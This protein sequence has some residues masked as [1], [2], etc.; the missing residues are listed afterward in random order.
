ML[1][2]DLVRNPVFQLAQAHAPDAEELYRRYWKPLD[3][4]AWRQPVAQGRL[5]RPRIDV[6]STTG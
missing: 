1:A 3:S 2:A 6:S 5:Y 4:D